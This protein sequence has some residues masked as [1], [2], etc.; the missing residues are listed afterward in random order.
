MAVA[1]SSAVGWG[2]GGKQAAGKCDWPYPR[3]IGGGGSAWEVAGERRRRSRAD[4]ASE[5]RTAVK[6]GAGFNNVLHGQLP[7]GL[8]KVL[9]G[10]WA[11]RIDGGASSAM[12]VRRRP[13]KVG[14]RRVGSLV[15]PTREHA[16]SVWARR[17]SGRA[18]AAREMDRAM[19]SQRRRQ[20]R[21]AVLDGG[22]C[23][24]TVGPRT[25]LYMRGR[26]IGG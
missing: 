21:T 23:A 24:R 5:A 10:P 7:C 22:V 9:G 4:A 1:R 26:S 17:G 19:S 15:R 3:S 25:G 12:A 2:L 6:I 14:L 13:R 11:W 18:Q 16:S 8:G 20:W